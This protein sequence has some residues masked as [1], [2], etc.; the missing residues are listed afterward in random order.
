MQLQRLVITGALPCSKEEA[1]SLAAIQLRLEECCAPKGRN[2]ASSVNR[3]HSPF[4]SS[5]V[6]KR[7][8][9][10]FFVTSALIC[11]RATSGRERIDPSIF[12]N[13]TNLVVK[14]SWTDDG[15]CTT[16]KTEFLLNGVG[17]ICCQLELRPVEELWLC[18]P[19]P[20]QVEGRSRHCGPSA[21]IVCFVAL[22]S[23]LFDFHPIFHL[24]IV[25]GS[26][27]HLMCF[28]LTRGRPVNIRRNNRLRHLSTVLRNPDSRP[29]CWFRVFRTRSTRWTTCRPA[30]WWSAAISAD[31]WPAPCPPRAGLPSSADATPPR[32]M[33]PPGTYLAAPRT[34]PPWPIV[35]RRIIGRPNTSKN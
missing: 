25:G 5:Q 2:L 17:A 23:F 4:A 15:G 35:C 19:P 10:T 24:F 30:T 27:L 26:E 31:T 22:V 16:A 20:R 3:C 9:L 8:F 7:F 28:L 13:I 14:L 34:V 33:C 1:A 12:S 32:A 11:S 29:L 18:L 6:T 21:L